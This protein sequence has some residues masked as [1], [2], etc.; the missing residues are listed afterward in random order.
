MV[1]GRQKAVS[2]ETRLWAIVPTSYGVW[3]VWSGRPL[4]VSRE[5]ESVAATRELP[6]RGDGT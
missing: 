2:R 6:S 5:T 1:N 4:L 3:F